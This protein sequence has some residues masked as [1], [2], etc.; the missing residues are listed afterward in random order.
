MPLSL[1]TTSLLSPQYHSPLLTP[2][3][4]PFRGRVPYLSFSIARS[5]LPA[6]S[7][8]DMESPI[9]TRKPRTRK[10]VNAQI[11]ALKK[12]VSVALKAAWNVEAVKA[13][14]EKAVRRSR[15]T[16]EAK[17]EEQRAALNAIK[18]SV[19]AFLVA[20]DPSAPVTPEGMAEFAP[21]DSAVSEGLVEEVAV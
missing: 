15:I 2:S 11:E 7:P 20:L 10:P 6:I 16:L 17:V 9:K 5:P 3:Q 19:D 21:V 13:R 14:R 18:A 4:S 8:S 1:S 12:S